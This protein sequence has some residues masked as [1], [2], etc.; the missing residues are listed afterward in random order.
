MPRKGWAVELEGIVLSGSY[1]EG[2]GCL[3]LPPE[4]LGPPPVR[5]EDV[6]YPQR[7]GVEHFADWYE[8]RI[9]T[10]EASVCP[11]GDSCGASC[12]GA[13]AHVRDI[14]QAWGR[15][16]DDVE[17]KIWTDCSDSIECP[18]DSPGSPGGGPF[19]WWPLNGTPNTN[20]TAGNSGLDLVNPGGGTIR[21]TQGGDGAEF[22]TTATG[23]FT[24]GRGLVQPDHQA[25]W[26]GMFQTPNSIPFE[27]D[28]DFEQE[29]DL[30]DWSSGTATISRNTVTPIA[31][32]GDLLWQWGADPLVAVGATAQLATGFTGDGNTQLQIS[33]SCLAN[34]PIVASS[35]WSVVL[36]TSGGVVIAS[37]EFPPG[38]TAYTAAIPIPNG[39][40]VAQVS[41]TLTD[42]VEPGETRIDN[43]IVRAINT[44]ILPGEVSVA[45]IR[46]SASEVAALRALVMPDRTLQI[47]DSTGTVLGTLGVL[48]TGTSYQLQLVANSATGAVMAALYGVNGAMLQGFTATGNLTGNTLTG[49]D[50]GV[51]SSNPSMGVIWWDAKMES[52]RLSPI[53]PAGATLPVEDR[54]LVGPY[55][56]IGRP[57]LQQGALTWLRGRSGCARLQLRFDARDH[58]MF[59]LDCDG[60]SEPQCVRTDPNIETSGR[61]YPRCYTGEGMCYDCD[62]GRESGDATATVVGTEC[63]SP[64]VCFNGGLTNPILRNLTT[65]DEVGIRGEILATD[66]PICVDTENGTATQGGVSRNYLLTGNPRFRLVPGENVLRLISTSSTDDGYVETCWRSFVV[67]A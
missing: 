48:V 24:I 67:S 12:P 64:E 33:W 5:T 44:A 22:R 18:D 37:R 63:A 57:R 54:S 55:G 61:A 16:C 62:T 31:G 49:F 23:S 27:Q 38:D 15:K 2:D 46:Q 32:T 45:T 14:L 50:I 9:I 8:P 42:P 52:G 35:A 6:V 10:L 41:I 29:A 66:P 51:V 59:I 13:R 39:Q 36:S 7:D 26:L 30:A 28:W 17:L 11:G 47:R 34:P 20:V 60:G 40:T 53:P 43:V 1:E 19:E 58:R 4:G 21:Y 56:I 3:I 25:S 65:G